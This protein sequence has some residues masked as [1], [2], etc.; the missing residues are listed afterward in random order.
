MVA[1]SKFMLLHPV[2]KMEMVIKPFCFR[3]VKSINIK[4]HQTASYRFLYC[5]AKLCAH[6]NGST[7]VNPLKKQANNC[8]VLIPVKFSTNR[9][10]QLKT[11][12]KGTWISNGISC[13]VISQAQHNK[14]GR[15]IENGEEKKRHVHVLSWVH[16]DRIK[17]KVELP[18]LHSTHYTHDD[19]GNNNTSF[20]VHVNVLW[21]SF[22]DSRLET[23][24]SL[25][26]WMKEWRKEGRN[27]WMLVGFT[28]C[29]PPHVH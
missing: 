21:I 5:F 20:I 19:E 18:H 12:K 11:S 29:V 16:S 3:N 23:L 25:N 6:T 17:M 27:E 9:H 10:R 15:K 13:T 8:F 1:S 26:E 7:L 2:N 14:R 22:S 4:I 28:T 24:V